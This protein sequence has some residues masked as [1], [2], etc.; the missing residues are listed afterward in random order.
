[1]FLMQGLN[2]GDAVLRK[3]AGE[4]PLGDISAAR[5]VA[6]SFLASASLRIFYI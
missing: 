4:D 5:S 2:D 3:H 1:M 6:F